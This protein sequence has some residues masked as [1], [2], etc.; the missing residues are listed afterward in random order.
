MLWEIQENKTQRNRKQNGSVNKIQ[1]IQILV[2]KVQLLI[3][4]KVME[5]NHNYI[6]ERSFLPNAKKKR[7]AVRSLKNDLV[8]T[9]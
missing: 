9:I 6:T 3:G 2:V 1:Q 8:K 5:Q 7:T 4:E